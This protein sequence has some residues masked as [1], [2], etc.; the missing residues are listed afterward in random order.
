MIHYLKLTK[1]ALTTKNNDS[2]HIFFNKWSILDLKNDVI[3]YN[4]RPAQKFGHMRKS[5]LRIVNPVTV[6]S[7]V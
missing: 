5:P 4:V 3:E 1:I 7:G 2:L 6:I